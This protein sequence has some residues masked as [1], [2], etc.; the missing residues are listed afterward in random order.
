MFCDALTQC[1]ILTVER[2]LLQVGFMNGQLIVGVFA[3]EIAVSA[4]KHSSPVERLT[5]AA[6]SMN[7]MAK[8]KYVR[9]TVSCGT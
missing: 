4:A 2:C 8:S 6:S 3:Q 7:Q 1:L 5:N 9:F